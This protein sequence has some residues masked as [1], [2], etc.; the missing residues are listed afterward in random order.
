MS[1]QT[2]TQESNSAVET[3]EKVDTATDNAENSGESTEG[4]EGEAF[5]ASTYEESFGLPAD[6]LKGVEN[7]ED[8]LEAIRG[9]TDKSLTT[10]LL[11]NSIE[12][13]TQAA[14]AAEAITGVETGMTTGVD[15]GAASKK[16]ASQ[17]SKNPELDALRAKVDGMEKRETERVRL[18]LEARSSEIDSRVVAEIDKWA[19]PKYGTTKSRNFKQAKDV[20]EFEDLVRT[21][22]LGHR[23]EGTQPPLV[24]KLL[25][26]VR[27][28][29]D[30][31]FNPKPVKDN[32][33]AV[34][35]SPGTGSRAAKKG[36]DEPRSIHQALQNNSYV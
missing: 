28:F 1:S 27:A 17:A 25:R 34:L 6:T 35:G 9:Y 2:E 24:E 3:D 4:G 10:G 15:T 18:D 29:H 23:A 21:H 11:S 5:D 16:T 36:D 32:G 33:D 14:A 22:I 19:S 31:D 8:A 26:Q 20:K 12:G 7:A 13:A 30:E